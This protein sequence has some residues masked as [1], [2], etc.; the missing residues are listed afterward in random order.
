MSGAKLSESPYKLH[1]QELVK[2]VEPRNQTEFDRKL[3]KHV[4]SLD[5]AIESERQ[6]LLQKLETFS[7]QLRA[8][9]AKSQ[10]VD[11]KVYEKRIAALAD[12]EEELTE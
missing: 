4:Q 11:A 2:H 8:I 10:V 5:L 9:P 6:E 3:I 7:Q 12:R 1:L